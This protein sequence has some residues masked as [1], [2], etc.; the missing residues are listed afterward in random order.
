MSWI[1]MAELE[2]WIN[3]IDRGGLWQVNDRTYS[4]FVIM[5]EVV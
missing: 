4:L 3:M 1:V 2:T 5:E